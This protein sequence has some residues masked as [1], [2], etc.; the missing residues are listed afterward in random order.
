MKP[1]NASRPSGRVDSHMGADLMYRITHPVRADGLFIIDASVKVGNGVRFLC[2]SRSERPSPESIFH[3]CVQYG[4]FSARPYLVGQAA[5]DSTLSCVL[6]LY[7]DY[8]RRSGRN[9]TELLVRAYSG[10][11]VPEDWN[12][13]AWRK[14][15]DA[16]QW[17][18]TTFPGI[19]TSAAILG[20][21]ISL[22][23]QRRTHLAAVLAAALNLPEVPPFDAERS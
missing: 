21:L 4:E 2:E 16:A 1:P 18:G 11:E 14:V 7:Y 12:A 3:R 8:C 10:G 22:R 13:I 5:D 15:L 17:H 19:W 23:S 6:G 9:A 20:L